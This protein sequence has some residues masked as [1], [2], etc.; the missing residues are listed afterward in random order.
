MTLQHKA[1]SIEEARGA[2]G[3]R[4]VSC[5][6]RVGQGRWVRSP[7]R[8]C[9]SVRPRTWSFCTLAALAWRSLFCAVSYENQC[10]PPTLTTLD[11]HCMPQPQVLLVCSPSLH[12]RERHI[13][14]IAGQ[15]RPALQQTP[16][17]RGGLN[18]TSPVSEPLPV[19]SS[20]VL[21][22]GPRAPYGVSLYLPVLLHR[23]LY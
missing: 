7:D 16:L 10:L 12:P 9:P 1:Y 3:R 22:L 13:M 2:L 6:S 5:G 19:C 21:P 4:R 17:L 23:S 15:L 18:P 20:W 8:A 11:T 14:I